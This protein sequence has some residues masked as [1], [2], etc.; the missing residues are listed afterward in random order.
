[1]EPLALLP[2][3]VWFS[4]GR[5]SMRVNGSHQAL[6]QPTEGLSLPLAD[7]DP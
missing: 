7:S 1:M 5:V 2:S 6:V 4:D 3:P